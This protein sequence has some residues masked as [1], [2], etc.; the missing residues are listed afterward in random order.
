MYKK[1]DVDLECLIEFDGMIIIY[2]FRL[3][4]TF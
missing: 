1:G 2:F 3:N 4:L